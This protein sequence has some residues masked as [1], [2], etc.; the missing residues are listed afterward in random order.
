MSRSF[1]ITDLKN[2]YERVIA[3]EPLAPNA[4]TDTAKKYAK[5]L[6]KIN[7]YISKIVEH[8]Q[9]VIEGSGGDGGDIIRQEV[10]E[11]AYQKKVFLTLT[12]RVLLDSESDRSRTST[13]T[14]MNDDLAP[15]AQM[16]RTV[17]KFTGLL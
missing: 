9:G 13:D 4:S 6:K 16:A 1:I 7:Q 15:T 10:A 11:G 12:T 5:K 17:H 14:D 2:S 8:V 3:L